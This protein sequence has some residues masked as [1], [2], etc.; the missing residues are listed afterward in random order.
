VIDTEGTA[1][2]TQSSTSG[3]SKEA[4]APEPPVAASSGE[5]PAA[6]ETKVSIGRSGIK[7]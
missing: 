6:S 2:A 1:S 7:S 3:G 4:P 5:A